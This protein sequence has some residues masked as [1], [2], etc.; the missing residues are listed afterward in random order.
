MIDFVQQGGLLGERLLQLPRVP[1]L[2]RSRGDV[3]DVGPAAPNSL[4]FP[5]TKPTTNGKG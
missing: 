1:G 3:V 2:G 5:G 4:L